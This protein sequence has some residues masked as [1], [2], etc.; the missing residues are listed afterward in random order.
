MENVNIYELREAA[1]DMMRESEEIIN[2]AIKS[3]MDLDHLGS[4]DPDDL[5]TYGSLKRGFDAFKKFV[6]V[7]TD[8]TTA[9][10]KRQEEIDRKLDEI[11]DKLDEISKKLDK[12]K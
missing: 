12:L 9:T 2:W 7:E 3:S 11:D 6:K 4:L 8:A 1:D 10:Y 5:K